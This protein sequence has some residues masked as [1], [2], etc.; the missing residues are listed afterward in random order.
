MLMCKLLNKITVYTEL[1]L[2][3]ENQGVQTLKNCIKYAHFMLPHGI[4][5]MFSSI[6]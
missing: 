3:L 1:Y 2:A 6:M 4:F 5:K